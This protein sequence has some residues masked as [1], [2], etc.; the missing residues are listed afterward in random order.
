MEKQK[1]KTILAA[2]KEVELN[3]NLETFEE[4]FK[5]KDMALHLWKKF[6]KRYNYRIFDLYQ[7]LDSQNCELFENYLE[8]ISFKI[9]QTEE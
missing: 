8:V 3:S 2:L 9:T 4:I 7:V 5:C 6:T 1:I